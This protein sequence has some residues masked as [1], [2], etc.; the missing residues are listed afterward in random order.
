MYDLFSSKDLHK[1]Y[2]HDHK[3]LMYKSNALFMFFIVLALAYILWFAFDVLMMYGAPFETKMVGVACNVMKHV[4]TS[5]A[6]MDTCVC[7]TYFPL[8]AY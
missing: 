3:K 8:C 2:L 4:Y 6:S 7:A 1:H 5:K